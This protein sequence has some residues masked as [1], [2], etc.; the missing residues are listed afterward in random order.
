MAE[1]IESEADPSSG[2]VKESEV[3]V[4]VT[5][6]DPGSDGMLRR[7]SRMSNTIPGISRFPCGVLLAQHRI[8]AIFLDEIRKYSTVQVQHNVVPIDMKIDLN[9]TQD[10]GSYAI[11]VKLRQTAREYPKPIS[12]GG[13]QAST[14]KRKYTDDEQTLCYPETIRAKYVIGCDGAHSWTRAQLGFSMEGEQTEYIWGVLGTKLLEFLASWELELM[15]EATDI[16]PLTDFPDIRSRCKISA[17]S[18]TIMIIPREDGLVRIY[19]QLSAVAPGSDGRFDRS[20]I[21]PDTILEAAQEIIKP[22]KL[23]YKYRDWWTV[24]QGI[25]NPSILKT[26]ETERRSVAQELIAFD[27]S[28]SKLWSSR[29]K[30]ETGD[31]SGVSSTDFER[32]FVKQQLFTSGFGVHYGPGILTAK[33]SSD[34]TNGIQGSEGGEISGEV[35]L[36]NSHQHLAT[37]TM[38]GQRFPSFKVVNHCDALSWQFTRWLSADGF[39]SIVLFA[40]DVSEPGQMERVHVFASEMTKRSHFV[41]LRRGIPTNKGS[42]NGNLCRAREGVAQ[43]LTIHS[44][45]RQQVEFHDFPPLLRPYDEKLGYDYNRIFVDGESYYEGHGHAYDGYGVDRKTGCVMVVRPDQYVAWIGELEDVQGLEAY[46]A[47]ILVL[48]SKSC[49]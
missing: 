38:L 27:Q 14:R 49:M 2:H 1:A 9:Q 33:S 23:G 10:H 15:G 40:G 12:N 17:E 19:C 28:Y 20:R 30:K 7:A 35:V 47:G 29:P 41:P 31:Q 3:D 4:F 22:Y 26:Y 18:G 24:Y 37:K 36:T 16:I 45:P 39:F 21:K 46:F 43:L 42:C 32:A 34:S 8:E 44:A 5:L 13:G 11:T 25:A 6:Q 48:P